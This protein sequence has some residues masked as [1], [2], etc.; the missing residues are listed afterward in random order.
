[1]L[2]SVSLSDWVFNFTGNRHELAITDER[3]PI[4][5]YQFSCS[6][7]ESSLEDCTNISIAKEYFTPCS[8]EIV[9]IICEC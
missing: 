5:Y 8:D 1:M 2:Y 6:G 3:F 4:L 9:Y 7:D